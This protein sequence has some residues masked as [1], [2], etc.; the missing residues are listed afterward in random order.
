[1]ERRQGRRTS[2]G[3][4]WRGRSFCRSRTALIRCVGE[5]CGEVDPAA[6]AIIESWPADFAEFVAESGTAAP[7]LAAAE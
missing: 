4:G 7:V 3:S 2:K 1:L 5:Y 6:L